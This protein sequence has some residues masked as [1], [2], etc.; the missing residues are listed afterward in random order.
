MLSRLSNCGRDHGLYV[1]RLDYFSGESEAN[2]AV[3]QTR[4]FIGVVASIRAVSLRFR[5]EGGALLMLISVVI[6]EW[7]L[8]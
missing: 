2:V 8:G 6:D 3:E 5:V 4:F 7:K 1:L